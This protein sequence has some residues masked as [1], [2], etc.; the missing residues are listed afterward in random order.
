MRARRLAI[1]AAVLLVAGCV[2]ITRR[3]DVNP[4]P[5]AP[6]PRAEVRPPAPLSDNPLTWQP[7][8]WDWAGHGYEWRDGRW[9]DRQGHGPD[10]LTGYWSDATGVW[11]WMPAH[12][13]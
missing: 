9:I 10:W 13:M 1:L 12:W 4:Y 8:H 11:L 7:G 3:P 2:S 5:P 6:V